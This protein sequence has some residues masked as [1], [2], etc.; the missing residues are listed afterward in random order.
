MHHQRPATVV[1]ASHGGIA[2]GRDLTIRVHLPALQREAI[3][4]IHRRPMLA[5][6]LASLV[7]STLAIL[8]MLRSL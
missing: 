7:S 5:L 6:I 3:A 8:A 4:A 2:A 1:R